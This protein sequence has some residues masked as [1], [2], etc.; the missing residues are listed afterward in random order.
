MVAFLPHK[1]CELSL[2]VWGRKEVNGKWGKEADQALQDRAYLVF[3]TA[4]R[5]RD[6]MIRASIASYSTCRSTSLKQE[7]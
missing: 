5:G 7:D 2:V 6:V 4:G 1:F 3:F